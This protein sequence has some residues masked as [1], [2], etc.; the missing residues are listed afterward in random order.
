[1]HDHSEAQ[2]LVSYLPAKFLYL[3]AWVMSGSCEEQNR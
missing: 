1:M 3:S 2:I